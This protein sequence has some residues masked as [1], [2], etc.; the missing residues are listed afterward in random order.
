[1]NWWERL[2]AQPKDRFAQHIIEALCA[3]GTTGKLDYDPDKFQ[4]DL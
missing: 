2:E 4:I 3:S 1:M